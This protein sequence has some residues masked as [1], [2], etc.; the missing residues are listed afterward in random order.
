MRA[1]ADL[2]E[3][4]VEAVFLAFALGDVA[5]AA[6]GGGVPVEDLCLHPVRPDPAGEQLGIGVRPHQLRRRGVEVAGHTDDRQGGSA[7]IETW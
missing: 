7:S 6:T 5:P 3:A 1:G 4:A 2:V